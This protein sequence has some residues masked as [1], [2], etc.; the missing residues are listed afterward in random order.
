LHKIH[1]GSI[2]NRP[3]RLS[4]KSKSIRDLLLRTNSLEKVFVRLL[5]FRGNG[6]EIFPQSK[7]L[8]ARTRFKHDLIR[9]VLLY[10][11]FEMKFHFLFLNLFAAYLNSWW[12]AKFP[13]KILQDVIVLIGA[14]N[15]TKIIVA[16]IYHRLSYFGG[17]F[18]RVCIFHFFF[19]L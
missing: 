15:A 8:D 17:P 6:P 14:I 19:C 9:Y 12:I 18:K 3:Y 7:S 13:S 16:L 4:I 10:L 11:R 1:V 2:Y 5:L